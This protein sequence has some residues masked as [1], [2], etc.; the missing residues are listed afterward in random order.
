M[1]AQVPEQ[2]AA[3]LSYP[4]TSSNPTPGDRDRAHTARADPAK[5]TGPH[6]YRHYRAQRKPQDS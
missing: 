6:E 4:L 1:I 5:A 2:P 3:T